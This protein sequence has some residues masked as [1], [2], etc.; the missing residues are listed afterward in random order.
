MEVNDN[1]PVW[2]DEEQRKPLASVRQVQ[3][4]KCP[5]I[6]MLK[7]FA[8]RADFSNFFGFPSPTFI[9]LMLYNHL[10]SPSERTVGLLQPKDVDRDS[11]IGTA[12][13]YGLD[14][15]GIE[16]LLIPVAERSKAGIC[17][18]SLAGIEG[19][20]PAGGT[21]VS[22]V[23][24][25]AKTK[26]RSQDNQDKETNMAKV[27]RQKK[28]RNSWGKTPVTA[29]FSAPSQIGTGAHPAFCKGYRVSLPGVKRG[30]WVVL[31][32]KL[33]LAPRLKKD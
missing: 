5:R 21:D 9:P 23:C 11:W 14:G 28:R 24:C 16:S 18:R 6:F 10:L 15:P 8:V 1:S 29:T 26:Q 30:R 27:Q 4:Q 3:S 2:T 25:T 13:R 31:T 12:T 22:V 20:I 7:K 17:N 32:T 19:S 33:H